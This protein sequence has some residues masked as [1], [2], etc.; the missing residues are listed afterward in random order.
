MIDSSMNSIMWCEGSDCA[1]STFVDGRI[2]YI[3]YRSTR[4]HT[5]RIV[6]FPS[7]NKLILPD[8]GIK[9]N[10]LAIEILARACAM[11]QSLPC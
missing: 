9:Q 4:L 8:I 5:I 11:L 10:I 6:E 3:G 7:L 1:T 2:Q